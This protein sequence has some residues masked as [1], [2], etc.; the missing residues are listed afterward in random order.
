MLT[1]L[2]V[3]LLFCIN[4]GELISLYILEELLALVHIVF[5]EL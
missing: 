1:E 4:F 2:G 5:V 3:N